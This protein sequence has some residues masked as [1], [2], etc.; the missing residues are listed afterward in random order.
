MISLQLV[1][2]LRETDI[3][4]LFRS[5]LGCMKRPGWKSTDLVA[6]GIILRVVIFFL[7]RIICMYSY[8]HV[9][10]MAPM[11]G[12]SANVQDTK[13]RTS[14]RMVSVVGNDGVVRR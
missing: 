11:S 2:G 12:A 1:S 6:P 3:G 8:T 5:R 9:L 4:R 13:A 7:H 10:P 14:F